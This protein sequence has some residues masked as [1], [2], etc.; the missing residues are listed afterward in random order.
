MERLLNEFLHLNYFTDI[1]VH[2]QPCKQCCFGTGIH[3]WYQDKPCCSRCEYRHIR[4]QSH[5]LQWHPAYSDSYSK[6]L[7]TVSLVPCPEG[8]TVTEDGCTSTLFSD[9]LISLSKN[10]QLFYRNLD[11]NCFPWNLLWEHLRWSS[12]TC[13]WISNNSHGVSYW[14]RSKIGVRWRSSFSGL[15]SFISY[16]WGLT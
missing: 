15:S 5:Q 14:S 6:Y 10:M 13:L 3:Q 2:I 16:F 7:L 1:F 4:L 9:S 11:I 12:S 8:V